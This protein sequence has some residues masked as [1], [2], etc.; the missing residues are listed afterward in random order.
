MDPKDYQSSINDPFN[1]NAAGCHWPS[2]PRSFKHT[3]HGIRVYGPFSSLLIAYRGPN[4]TSHGKQCYGAF[5]EL[6]WDCL[7]LS[8]DSLL[9]LS[10]VW[11]NSRARVLARVQGSQT[12]TAS[13]GGICYEISHD[14]IL[15]LF[16]LICVRDNSRAFVWF[17]IQKNQTRIIFFL[18]KSVESQ[19]S[20]SWGK[21]NYA[22]NQLSFIPEFSNTG[23]KSSELYFSIESDVIA[24]TR[25]LLC[26]AGLAFIYLFGARIIF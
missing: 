18:F 23:M 16:S 2:L 19:K 13:Y 21:G 9:G 7:R 17:I 4:P 11:G 10:K 25:I 5:W 1:D 24:R 15:D 14:S 12:R 3:C 22:V 8:K 20:I 6:S 26:C